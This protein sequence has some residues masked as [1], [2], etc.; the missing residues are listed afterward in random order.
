MKQHI[1][2]V[3]HVVYQ[4]D[5]DW[6]ELMTEDEKNKYYN[7]VGVK[8]DRAANHQPQKL[9]RNDTKIRHS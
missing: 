2:E 1:M 9:L 5:P 8:N 6:R 4:D 7:Q 3:H